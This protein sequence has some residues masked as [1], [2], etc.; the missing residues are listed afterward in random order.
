RA[1]KGPI[2]GPEV[3]VSLEELEEAFEGRSLYSWSR[4]RLASLLVEAHGEPLHRD[5]AAEMLGA[6]T[7]DHGL[8]PGS[9]NRWTRGAVREDEEG[10]WTLD[11]EDPQLLGARR[12]LRVA[13]AEARKQK[14]SRRMTTARIAEI[15]ARAAEIEE[16]ERRALEALRRCLVY[17]FPKQRP[18]QIV[19]LDLESREMSFFEQAD[20]AAARSC[21]EG[22]EWI[23]ALDVRPLLTAVEFDAGLRHLAELGPPQKT[24]AIPGRRP[25]KITA[26]AM[27]KGC[28][29][30]TKPFGDEKAMRRFLAEGKTLLLKRR[31]A[32]A[33]ES[34]FGLYHYCKLHGAARVTRG[35]V[36][37]MIPAPWV[38]EA[39]TKL[40]KLKAQAFEHGLDIEAAL[41]P[42][43]FLEDP[44]RH[45]R[46][47]EPFPLGRYRYG[48][49]DKQGFQ[50][51]EWMV[52]AARLVLTQHEA[53]G[54]VH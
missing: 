29:N 26:E 16:R 3:P 33:M 11:P 19:I 53:D 47:L 20:F 38:R 5:R 31:L 9:T 49:M 15:R 51:E 8:R 12:A 23:G 32:K 22:Y 44:W 40:Y 10:Y 1:P 43:L 4:Q 37:V 18:E 30:K 54:T 6:W 14:G 2:P 21:L 45:S 39:E 28:S 52:L 50:V 27:A 34:L 7:P 46:R 13:L 36:E 17:G 48:L 35:D 24:T 42:Y 25:L 41:G